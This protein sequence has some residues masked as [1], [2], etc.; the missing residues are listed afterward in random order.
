MIKKLV[1]EYELSV[2]EALSMSNQKLTDKITHIP[3][4]WF[5]MAKKVVKPM[6]QM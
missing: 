5:D 3:Q 6:Q 2:N 1:K 4:R